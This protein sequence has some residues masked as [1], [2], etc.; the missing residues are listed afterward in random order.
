MP[1]GVPLQQFVPGEIFAFIVVFARLGSTFTLLPGFGESFIP[2]RVRLGIALAVTFVVTPLVRPILPPLPDDMV[3]LLS[4]LF[5]EVITGM[6]IGV[7][8][9]LLITTL[10][11]A[12]TFI[13]FQ[14]GLSAA[15]AFNPALSQSGTIVGAF[16]ALAGVVALFAT[17]MHYLVLRAL[18]D[19]YTLFRPGSPPMFGDMAFMFAQLVSQSFKMA[20]QIAMP[21]VVLG[22]LFNVVLGLISRLM[23][24]IQIFFVGIPVQLLGGVLI[25]GLTSSAV[26][27]FF[28]ANFQ[29]TLQAYLTPR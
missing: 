14:T 26:V 20:L 4:I 6:F 9:R 29:D 12:G 19:S 2:G 22:L 28:L 17:D 1:F 16:L 11:T 24:Q 18:V 25:L 8:T 21:F 7:V 10:D 13:S 27:T 5:T 3:R 15:Q 23:P